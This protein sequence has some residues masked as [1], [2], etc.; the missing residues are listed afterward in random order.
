MA[1]ILSVVGTIAGIAGISLGIVLLIYR[2]FLQKFIQAKLFKTLSSTQATILIGATIIFTFAIAVI[3]IFSSFVKDGSAI[4]FILLVGILLIFI[5]AVLYIVKQPERVPQEAKQKPAR[6]VFVKVEK[7]SSVEREGQG[8]H[9]SEFQYKAVHTLDF[10]L[11]NS[12]DNHLVVKKIELH[13]IKSIQHIIKE[14]PLMYS[15]IEAGPLRVFKIDAPKLSR[16][17]TEYTLQN[18]LIEIEQNGVV[19]YKTKFSSDENFLFVVKL[20]FEWIDAI[21]GKEEVS[22]SDELELDFPIYIQ[23]RQISEVER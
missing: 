21:T 17:K 16:T 9:S 5:V 7:N 6:L 10:L 13:I 1:D 18:R 2:D 20:S 15:T 19:G 22:F 11:S 8:R 4:F 23:G 12:G 14:P 3:G